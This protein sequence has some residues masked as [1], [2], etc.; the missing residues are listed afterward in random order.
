[1]KK[2]RLKKKISPDSWILLSQILGK[3]RVLEILDEKIE[4][5]VPDSNKEKND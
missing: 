5:L 3:D 2:K 1:M 4:N